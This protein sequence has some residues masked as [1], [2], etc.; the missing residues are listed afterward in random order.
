MNILITGSAGFVGSHVYDI[1][2]AAGHNVFGVDNLDP[3][4]HPGIVGQP[5]RVQR[6]S[7]YWDIPMDILGESDVLIHLAAQVGVADSMTDMYRYVSQN[8]YDNAL[9][10]DLITRTQSAPGF[11]LKHLI[12]ASSMSIYGDPAHHC[13]H[14]PGGL[15]DERAEI[16]PASIYGL[17]KYDQER[18]CLLW[19]QVSGIPVTALRFFNV[20]GERQALHNP[21]TGVIANFANW[22]LRDEQPVVY[23]DGQQTRDF[24]HVED[25]AR[26]VAYFVRPMRVSDMGGV[27]NI[28]T[29]IPTTIEDMARHLAHGLGK[30][31]EPNVTGEHRPG[32]VRHI[33]GD[34]HKLASVMPDWVPRSVPDGISQYCDWLLRSG[35]VHA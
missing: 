9:L 22:L 20:Y 33:I 14:T 30:D 25:V 27:F 12:V 21:Y 3:R 19:S 16:Q 23:E 26:A 15:V 35:V 32:D 29:A 34:S 8:T 4:I 10:L 17:T 18:Q 13:N 1:L 6:A 7:K 11:R 24:V 28:S 5:S 31:I 2:V